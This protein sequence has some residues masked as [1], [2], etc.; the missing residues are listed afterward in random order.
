MMT[1][2]VNFTHLHVTY[3]HNACKHR[4]F[5]SDYYKKREC[6]FVLAFILKQIHHRDHD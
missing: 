5:K 1:L 6:S 4:R 3:K 2:N